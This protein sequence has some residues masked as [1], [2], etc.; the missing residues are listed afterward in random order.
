MNLNS[1]R[2]ITTSADLICR[3]T[4]KLQPSEFKNSLT[5]PNISGILLINTR[6]ISCVRSCGNRRRDPRNQKVRIIVPARVD[7]VV[8]VILRVKLELFP[9]VR[10]SGVYVVSRHHHT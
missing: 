1:G 2:R 5:T 4:A 7:D 6:L 9:P 8:A 10:P 3:Y